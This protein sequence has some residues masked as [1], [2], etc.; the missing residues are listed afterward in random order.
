M[1]GL[2]SREVCNARAQKHEARAG[3][4]RYRVVRADGCTL[5]GASTMAKAM[6]TLACLSRD[7]ELDG[8]RIVT[9]GQR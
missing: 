6:E 1:N 4:L 9:R 7:G 2:D 8:Y 3:L 5:S